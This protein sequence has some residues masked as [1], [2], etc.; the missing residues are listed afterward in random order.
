MTFEKDETPSVF[1]V[2]PTLTAVETQAGALREF[3][4]P[5]FPE[6]ATVAIPTDLRLSMIGLYGS[7][8]QF[9]EKRPSPRLRFAAAKACWSRRRYTR[10]RPA[11]MSELH[12]ATHG[13]KK[14]HSCIRSN[15]ENTCIAMTDA[16]LATPENVLPADDPLPAAMPATCVPWSQP[17]SASE[18]L[19]PDP[20][21]TC[22]S[23]PFGQSVVLC[24]LTL[25]E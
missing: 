13:A 16:P 7:P 11:M 14:P 19:T 21:P 12:P 23:W 2:E 10:S 18:Q 6:A 25:L 17:K 15:R 22:S 9:D 5:P 1:V 24:G 3:D 4:D 20:G 8:S